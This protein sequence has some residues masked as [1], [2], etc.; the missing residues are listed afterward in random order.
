MIIVIIYIKSDGN[1]SRLQEKIITLEAATKNLEQLPNLNSEE[2]S[3]KLFD[4]KLQEEAEDKKW[5]DRTQQA[6]VGGWGINRKEEF[7]NQLGVNLSER[8]YPSLLVE[9]FLKKIIK[10]NSVQRAVAKCPH[11][12]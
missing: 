7:R 4:W 2:D 6:L 5:V 8:K 10:L 12:Q 9:L 1:M 11:L 3:N